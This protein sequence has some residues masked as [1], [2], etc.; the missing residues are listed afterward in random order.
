M[1]IQNTTRS[2][3]FKNISDSVNSNIKQLCMF[4]SFLLLLIGLF[5]AHK[6]WVAH[7]ERAAQ[8]DFSE[9]MTE[10]ETM[11]HEKNPEWSA[12]LEKFETNYQ[13]HSHS[14]LLP[15]YLG[16]K[17][18]ILLQQ[19]NRSEA[20]NTLNRAISEMVGSPIVAL[21]EM[22]RALIQLD[23]ENGEEQNIGLQALKTLAHDS[24]NMFRDSA[25]YYLGNY[26]WAHNDIEQARTVWQQLVN[27]QR[28]EKM[29]PSP[30]VQQ[31]RE[32]LSLTI[33]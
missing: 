9:L 32:Q 25:Q 19:D 2:T 12:L 13:K 15:Y 29:S 26:Y 16:Y 31:V 1:A 7:R 20:L 33:I 11:L 17:V 6:L 3:F 14:S 21:Y 18:K 4:F 5:F 10:Y 23:S 22:E 28:D 8:Y 27:E 30:W 24:N